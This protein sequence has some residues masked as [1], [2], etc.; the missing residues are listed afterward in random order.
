KHFRDMHHQMVTTIR[1]ETHAAIIFV[2]TIAPDTTRF[3][4]SVP[5]FFN[6]PQSVL[7]WMAEDR[8]RY[9]ETAVEIAHELELPLVNVYAATLEAEQNGTPLSTFINPAD[10]IHPSPAGNR[11]TAQLTVETIAK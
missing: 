5:N 8:M 2:V 3:L 10:W 9:L 6:T 4:E 11:L 1:A 7:R